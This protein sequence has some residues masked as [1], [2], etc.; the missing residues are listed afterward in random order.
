MSV[1]HEMGNI[2]ALQIANC[3]FQIGNCPQPALLGNTEQTRV[4]VVQP[5]FNFQFEIYNLQC[6]F[7]VVS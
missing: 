5:I 4:G 6:L 7:L 3:K 2:E 1:H